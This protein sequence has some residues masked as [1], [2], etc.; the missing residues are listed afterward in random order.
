MFIA[1]VERD[2]DVLVYLCSVAWRLVLGECFDEKMETGEGQL[3]LNPS[4]ELV[5]L[6]RH[7]TLLAFVEFLH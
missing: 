5:Q 2:E 6:W 4:A 1:G 7:K 3:I